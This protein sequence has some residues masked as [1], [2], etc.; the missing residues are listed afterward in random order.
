[1]ILLP[2]SRVFNINSINFLINF[3][4]ESF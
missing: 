3:P 2:R 4:L 1:V